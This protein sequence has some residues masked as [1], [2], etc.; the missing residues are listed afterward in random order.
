MY[1]N[2]KI[3]IELTKRKMNKL[4]ANT[5][6]INE[7]IPRNYSIEIKRITQT[8]HHIKELNMAKGNYR[9]AHSNI[10]LYVSLS[11]Y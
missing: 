6:L 5:L 4:L 1:T 8:S 3:Q 9:L 2:Y 11:E 7:I 10:I